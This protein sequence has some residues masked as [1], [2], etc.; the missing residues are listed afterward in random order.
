MS[1][2]G[3]RGQRRTVDPTTA[4]QAR[5]FTVRYGT[6]SVVVKAHNEREAVSVVRE[7]VDRYLTSRGYRRSTAEDFTCS[8]SNGQDIASA[9]R[10]YPQRKDQGVLGL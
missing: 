7:R 9:A 5:H 1:A 4:L 10:T 6:M 3:R 8:L 2:A